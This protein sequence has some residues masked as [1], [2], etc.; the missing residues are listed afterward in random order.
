MQL[1]LRK[2]EAFL[3]QPGDL[4]SSVSTNVQVLLA[5][6]TLHRGLYLFPNCF[7]QVVQS[8]QTGGKRTSSSLTF[9]LMIALFSQSEALNA[10][11]VAQ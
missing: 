2:L 3:E 10:S 11:P 5:L 9:E 7:V 1:I 8:K 6:K 4:T